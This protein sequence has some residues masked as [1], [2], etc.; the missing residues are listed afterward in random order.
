VEGGVRRPEIRHY[1]LT[2]GRLERVDPV[3]LTP[4]DF[5]A[6]WL[7]SRWT[8]IA[9][10]TAEGS[11]PK[12][13]QWLENHKGPFAEFEFPTRHCTLEPDLWQVDTD[14]GADGKEHV[15][16][17]MRWRP[18]WYFTMLSASELPRPDCTEEDRQ[19]DNARSLFLGR[20]PY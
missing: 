17:V 11:R 2:Q 9:G 7:R 6:F 10:R 12:L 15:Y 1:V 19:A 8:E 13:K 3:A 14:A 4:T 5:T 18:P 16:F 20:L